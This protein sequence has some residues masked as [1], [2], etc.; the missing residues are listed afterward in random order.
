MNRRTR[1]T[2]HRCMTLAGTVTRSRF[3]SEAGAD[4]EQAGDLQRSQSRRSKMRIWLREEERERGEKEAEGRKKERTS[5]EER[6]LGWAS[7]V[8]WQR[9]SVHHPPDC[10]VVAGL[11]R[12]PSGSDSTSEAA[13]YRPGSVGRSEHSQKHRWPLAWS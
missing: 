9:T 1:S 12:G 2:S 5:V 13:W 3:N 11:R 7:V 6:Q 8:S 10:L 4:D